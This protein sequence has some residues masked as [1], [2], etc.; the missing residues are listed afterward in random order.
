[1]RSMPTG[2]R[3]PLAH[4]LLLAAETIRPA[5]ASGPAPIPMP[6]LLTDGKANVGLPDQP[7]DAWEQAIQ[8]AGNLAAAGVAALVLDSEAGFVRLGRAREIAMALGAEYLGLDDLTAESLT[9][10]VRQRLCAARAGR[11]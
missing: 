5:R 4:A 2:G 3:T 10:H 7:G 9:L 1:M 8:A 6:V 11:P